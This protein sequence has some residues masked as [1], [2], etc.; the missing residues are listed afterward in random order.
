MLI[1][2]RVVLVKFSI[3]CLL[4]IIN[5]PLLWAQIKFVPQYLVVNL[6]EQVSL[7]QKIIIKHN[8]SQNKRYTLKVRHRTVEENNFS[9]PE[10]IKIFPSSLELIPNTVASIKLSFK[11][12]PILDKPEYILELFLV[13]EL[14]GQINL[15]I[16]QGIP[17]FIKK[18]SQFKS[19]GEI[20]NPIVEKKIKDKVKLVF[21][22]NNTGEIHLMPL[23]M[24]WLED[25]AGHRY[26]YQ[27]IRLEKIIFPHKK[28]N[29]EYFL[30]SPPSSGEYYVVIKMFWGNLYKLVESQITL[31]EE[32]RILFKVK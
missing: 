29:L 20:L 1:T 26:Q 11:D 18:N 5:C 13:E 31:S 27:E 22:I 12:L 25:K 3:L 32:K 9:I 2:S 24:L 30:S 15:N 21:S 23:G 16:L 17:I 10:G 14:S 8:V 6:D 19:K 7:E 4:S 28:R